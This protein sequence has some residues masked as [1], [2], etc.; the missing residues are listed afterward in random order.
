[1]ERRCHSN[2]LHPPIQRYVPAFTTLHLLYQ[3]WAFRAETE[4]HRTQMGTKGKEIR[5]GPITST[6]TSDVKQIFLKKN[7]SARSGNNILFPSRL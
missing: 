2:D 7:S 4:D 1:M 5:A 3:S 6:V